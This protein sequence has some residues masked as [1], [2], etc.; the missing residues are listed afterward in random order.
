[1]GN[2]FIFQVLPHAHYLMQEEDNI[3]DALVL[4]KKKVGKKKEE[5][6]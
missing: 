3:Y 2:R 1:M 4:T 6:N 5:K